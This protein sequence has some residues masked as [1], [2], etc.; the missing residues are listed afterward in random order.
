MPSDINYADRLCGSEFLTD[1]VLPSGLLWQLP[2]CQAWFI[3]EP[4]QQQ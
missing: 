1:S 3:S 2:M 4:K